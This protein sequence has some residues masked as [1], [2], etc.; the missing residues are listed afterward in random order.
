[1]IT[2]L[3]VG[4]QILLTTV[5]MATASEV[6][7]KSSDLFQ[8]KKVWTIELEFTPEQWAAMEP[9]GGQNPFG[10]DSFGMGMFLAPAVMKDGD[11][12]KSKTLSAKEFQ[13]LG[14]RWFTSWDIDHDGKLDLKELQSSLNTMLKPPADAP[15]QGFSLQGEKG[16]R[17]GI[18]SIMGVEFKYVH[19]SMKFDEKRFKDVAVRFKG[20]GTFLES[21]GSL[22]RS[23]KIDLNRFEKG[24]SLAGVTTLNLHNNVTDAGWMNEALAYQ[25]YR[26]M[27]VPSPRL[28]YA[29]VYVTVPGKHDHKYL[30]LYSVVENV[31]KNFLKEALG[32]SAGAILKPVTPAFLADLGDDWEEY[33]QTFDPKSE[34]SKA[35]KQRLIEFCRLVTKADDA[36]FARKLGEYIDIDEFARYLAVT[37]MVSDLD[38]ILGMGQNMYLYLHPK[39]N[40]LVFIPWDQDH[41]FGQLGGG[42]PDDRIQLNIQK[43]WDG[44]K[45]FLERIFRVESFKALYL[46]RIAELSKDQFRP[47]RLDEQIVVLADLIRPAVKEES[48]EKL[49]R[50]ETVVAGKPLANAGFF[51]FGP[52]NPTLRIF[53]KD[54]SKSVADQLAGKSEGRT[55]STKRPGEPGGPPDFNPG[56]LL[57]PPLLKAFDTDADK[58]ITH[59]ELIAGFAR[60]YATWDTTKK[61]QLAEPQ[62]R[63]GLNKALP[64]TFGPPPA[65]PAEKKP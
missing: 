38:G 14:E 22:K 29:R 15:P 55:L 23:F 42:G 40:K 17:N 51:A 26:E 45:R 24:Q 9:E 49:T 25:L 3:F 54:R 64:F 5:A 47:E 16:K 33:V 2:K 6:P 39:T 34:L 35:Q 30:G 56:D 43:P 10:G 28:A 59:D 65:P 52:P 27:K 7:R 12:D 18:A 8:T 57:G 53:V 48:A 41:S 60:W 58:L 20:N 21:R 13:D 50:F 62:V 36:E 11:T 1:M 61:S 31:D 32:T 4:L 46:A 19:A 63:K 44:Q 37:V